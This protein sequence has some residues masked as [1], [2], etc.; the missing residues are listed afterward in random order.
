MGYDFN[1]GYTDWLAGYM[2]GRRMGM[3]AAALH[4]EGYIKAPLEP[5]QVATMLRALA[6]IE[7]RLN[8]NRP[9][10]SWSTR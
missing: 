2:E 3:E 9:R 10:A 6:E 4:F 7:D 1:A 8:P 5:K